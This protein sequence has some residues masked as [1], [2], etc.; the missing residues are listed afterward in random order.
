MVDN[1]AYG[2][3]EY[4]YLEPVD[5]TQDECNYYNISPDKIHGSVQRMESLYYSEVPYTTDESPQQ[6]DF[7]PT[8]NQI[9]ETAAS[10]QVDFLPTTNQ[11]YDTA[12][13]PQVDFLPTTNQIYDT[14]A[15]Q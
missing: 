9:Y 8:T 4:I 6:V 2:L 12:A 14:V 5:I 3:D 13:S 1:N 10:P 15:Y 11:I 7:L